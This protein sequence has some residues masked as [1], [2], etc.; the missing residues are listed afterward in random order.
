MA[1]NGEIEQIG[2]QSRPRAPSKASRTRR[3]SEPLLHGARADGR[4]NSRPVDFGATRPRVKPKAPRRPARPPMRH[5][6]AIPRDKALGI[7]MEAHA[8]L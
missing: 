1:E 5:S 3:L 7:A 6:V 8:A 2:T 4:S